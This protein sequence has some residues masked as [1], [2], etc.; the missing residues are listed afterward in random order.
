VLIFD[1]LQ[2]VNLTSPLNVFLT[3]DTKVSHTPFFL[4]PDEP[5][6]QTPQDI[7]TYCRH[8]FLAR[9]LP[10]FFTSGFRLT[11]TLV[12]VASIRR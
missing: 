12:V 10:A 1:V 11:V 8:L 2:L 5:G 3:I 4:Q 6:P 9:S 7:V